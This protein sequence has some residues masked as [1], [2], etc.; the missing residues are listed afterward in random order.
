MHQTTSHVSI[1]QK[2]MTLDSEINHCEFSK[3]SII[4]QKEEH[5]FLSVKE[6]CP[7]LKI[8]FLLESRP[9]LSKCALKHTEISY[10][11]DEGHWFLSQ[12]A[13]RATHI[14][15]WPPRSLRLLPMWQR[16]TRINRKLE[17]PKHF[18]TCVIVVPEK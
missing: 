16:N 4:M 8:Y 2:N 12:A 13:G 6:M 18:R 14:A 9:P 15:S 3:G 7:V 11:H 10:C 1:L 17:A 5:T